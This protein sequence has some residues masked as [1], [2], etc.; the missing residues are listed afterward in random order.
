[1]MIGVFPDTVYHYSVLVLLQ[2]GYQS[3]RK[4][5]LLEIILNGDT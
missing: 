4:R 2:I 5:L 3:M 1:M